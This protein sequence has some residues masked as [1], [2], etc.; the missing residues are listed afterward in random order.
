MGETHT[1]KTRLQRNYCT[2]S[3]NFLMQKK[4]LFEEIPRLSVAYLSKYF[5]EPL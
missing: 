3:E 5:V 1:H 2:L 4:I